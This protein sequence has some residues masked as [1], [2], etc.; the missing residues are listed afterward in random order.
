LGGP[1]AKMVLLRLAQE[2]F[3]VFITVDRN[4]AFQQDVSQFD[5]AVVILGAYKLYHY[6]WH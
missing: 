6:H 5:I 2:R 1:G 4:L 3:D